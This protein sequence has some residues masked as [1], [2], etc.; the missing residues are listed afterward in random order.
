MIMQITTLKVQQPSTRLIIQLISFTLCV[1]ISLTALGKDASNKHEMSSVAKSTSYNKSVFKAD[2]QYAK[3]KY[4][5]QAQRD[6]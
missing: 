5:A 2:P 6:I 1:S 4:D 3:Q